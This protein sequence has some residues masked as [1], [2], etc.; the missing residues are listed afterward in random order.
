MQFAML[1]E[2]DIQ[3]C[4][5]NTYS[6]REA[7]GKLGIALVTLQGHVK[8]KTFQV[9]RLVKVGGVRVRLWTDRDIARARKALAGIKPGPKKSK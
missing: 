5:V 1:A 4:I 3:V 7:A 6:T 9:P 8:K 2:S